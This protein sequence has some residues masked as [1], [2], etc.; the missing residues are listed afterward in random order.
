MEMYRALYNLLKFVTY[1]LEFIFL[2]SSLRVIGLICITSPIAKSLKLIIA[3]SVILFL[4]LTACRSFARTF[5]VYLICYG[6]FSMSTSS[7]REA[8]SPIMLL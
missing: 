2:M 5:F 8:S 4:R 6:I 1:S 3:L 7:D